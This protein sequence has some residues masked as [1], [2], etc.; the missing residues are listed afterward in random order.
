MLQ[1]QALKF[2]RPHHPLRDW[3]VGSILM[4][5]CCAASVWAGVVSV[6]DEGAGNDHPRSA[7]YGRARE[8]RIP[9]SLDEGDRQ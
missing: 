2:A 6:R 4:L 5:C 3:W 1:C 9:I 7:Q 8:K